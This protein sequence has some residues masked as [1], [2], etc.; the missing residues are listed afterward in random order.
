M[1][2]GA[3]AGSSE[4]EIRRIVADLG[5]SQSHFLGTFDKRFPGFIR[6]QV[7]ATAIVNTAGRETG[8]VHWLA[9]AWDPAS[10]TVTMFEPYGFSDQKLKQLYQFEYE[11]LLRRSAIAN[12]PDRCIQLVK[13]KESVQGIHSAACGLF[14]CL[15]VAAFDARP[16][17]PLGDRNPVMGPIRGVDNA[18]L[19]DP[20]AQP[21]LRDNQEY[22]YRY[23]HRHSPYFRAH[24]QRIRA[25][26]AFD[27]IP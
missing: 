4:S 9:L 18:R 13:S 22:L 17:D 21:T 1:G 16:G 10:R 24:E 8:G 15:F 25:A 27:R 19:R 14:C 23:L 6:E 3:P 5:T 2:D 11:G 12:S 26:T 20:S 7:R